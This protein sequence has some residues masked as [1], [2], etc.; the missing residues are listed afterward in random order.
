M[1]WMLCSS[2]NSYVETLFPN[3]MVSGGKGPGPLGGEEIMKV[4]V[5][6]MGFVPLLKKHRENSLALFLHV[7]TQNEDNG[8]WTT[9]RA[10]TS[11]W[12]FIHFDLGLPN[13]QNYEK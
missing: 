4:E 7:R 9:N 13:L 6:W 8:L 5:S 3:V 10:L 12:N 11:H 1:D 2:H